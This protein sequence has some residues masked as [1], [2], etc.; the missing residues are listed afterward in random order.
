MSGQLPGFQGNGPIG[1][2]DVLKDNNMTD[3]KL[4]TAWMDAL[5]PN[6]AKIADLWMKEMIA[7]FGTG[8]ANVSVLGSVRYSRYNT[9]DTNFSRFRSVFG[10][11]DHWWQLDGYFNGKT[12]PWLDSD[13]PQEVATE[14]TGGSLVFNAW[15]YCDR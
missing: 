11:T 7:D 13:V 8:K 3:N 6:Y 5:D 10:T 1:L 15:W 14:A 9:Q 12:A 2:K 4:G